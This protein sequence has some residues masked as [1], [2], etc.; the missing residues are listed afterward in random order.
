MRIRLHIAFILVAFSALSCQKNKFE[1]CTNFEKLVGEWESINADTDNRLIIKSD[2]E[3]YDKIGLERSKKIKSESCSYVPNSNGNGFH[4]TVNSFDGH[5]IYYIN[6]TF[7]TITKGRGAQ[8]I[9]KDTNLLY[10]LKYIK[11]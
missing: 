5:R 4:F 10:Q 2:G 8:D 6:N 1:S 3:I 9:S 11:I 7:D